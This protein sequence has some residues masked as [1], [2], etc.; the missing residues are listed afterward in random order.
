[1]GAE[2]VRFDLFCRST[3]DFDPGG[4]VYFMMNSVDLAARR[5]VHDEF[6]VRV[7]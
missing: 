2:T 4:S 6:V 1:L 5:L 7:T 3:G